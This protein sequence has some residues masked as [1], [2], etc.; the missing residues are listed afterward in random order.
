MKKKRILACILSTAMLITTMPLG[1]AAETD[2]DTTLSYEGYTL[3]W[4]DEFNG[5]TLNRDD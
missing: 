2:A 3:V 4:A 1:A 5:D